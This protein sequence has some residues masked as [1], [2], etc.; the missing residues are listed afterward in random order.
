MCHRTKRQVPSN[1]QWPILVLRI[2]KLV[3]LHWTNYAANYTFGKLILE[4]KDFI[5]FITINTVLRYKLPDSLDSVTFY[6]DIANRFIIC[7]G[8]KPFF[9]L[10]CSFNFLNIR[11]MLSPSKDIWE[12]KNSMHFV[13]LASNLLHRCRIP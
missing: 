11:W 6:F 12:V 3:C 2:W 1:E 13:S 4:A 9:S 8:K 10:N 5:T 7:S